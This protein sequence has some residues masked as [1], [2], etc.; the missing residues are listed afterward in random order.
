MYGMDD[1]FMI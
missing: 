1:V